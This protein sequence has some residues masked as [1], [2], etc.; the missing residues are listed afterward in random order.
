[1]W[2]N[3]P[4]SYFG[5]ERGS[6]LLASN[7]MFSP[8]PMKK[9]LPTAPVSTFVSS[10]FG[11]GSAYGTASTTCKGTQPG[12]RI[13]NL[14]GGRESRRVTISTLVVCPTKQAMRL[15]PPRTDFFGAPDFFFK[16]KYTTTTAFIGDLAGVPGPL[17]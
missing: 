14:A 11:R 4:T 12:C 17:G 7:I 3:R 5:T 16:R 2:E 6:T 15:P 8:S 10:G 1:M 9:E 13:T